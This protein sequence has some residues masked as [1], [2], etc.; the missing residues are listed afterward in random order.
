MPTSATWACGRRSD[1]NPDRVARV[2]AAVDYRRLVSTRPYGILLVVAHHSDN[3]THG[4]DGPRIPPCS[5]PNT[6]YSTISPSPRDLRIARA[7]EVTREITGEPRPA[8]DLLVTAH[9]ATNPS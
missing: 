6:T 1:R 4:V 7:D 2:E 5:T 8:L 3:L 9:R